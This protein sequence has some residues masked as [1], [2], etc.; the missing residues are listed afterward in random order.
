MTRSLQHALDEALGFIEQALEHIR[1]GEGSELELQNLRACLLDILA[2]IERNP[3]VEA[4]CDDL[5]ASAK[6][7][8]LGRDKGARMAR[9]MESSMLRLRERLVHALPRSADMAQS[10]P[11]AVGGTQ[12]RQARELLG[13]PASYLALRAKIS[14]A[15]IDKAETGGES[16]VTGAHWQAILAVLER[17]G[18]E[19]TAGATAGVRLSERKSKRRHPPSNGS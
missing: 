2:A 11:P 6:E 19:F 5:Y 10:S 3:G 14:T 8:A 9:L 15:A 1:A 7:L 13:W 16:A 12:I 4:A 18:V 17:A